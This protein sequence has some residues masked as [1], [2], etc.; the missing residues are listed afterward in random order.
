MVDWIKG[1]L[2]PLV[3]ITVV[4]GII[5]YVA[6]I[7]TKA[8]SNGWRKSGKFFFRY[9][10]LRKPFKERH[11]EWIYKSIESGLT[12]H[13]AKQILL[14]KGIEEDEID[15]IMWIYKKVQVILNKEKGGVKTVESWQKI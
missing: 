3:E 7:V 12:Y 8:F 2:I 5:L 10:L 6:F 9:A 15:E 14:V 11:T 1:F 4:G 13:Q